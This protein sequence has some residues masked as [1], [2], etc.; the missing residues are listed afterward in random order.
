MSKQRPF[1]DPATPVPAQ[2]DRMHTESA[3]SH[4][5]FALIGLLLAG[6][7]GCSIPCSAPASRSS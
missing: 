5:G 1:V 7:T 6:A 2:S 4:R 3:S